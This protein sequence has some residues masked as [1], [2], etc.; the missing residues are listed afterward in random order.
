M[1][2]TA[3]LALLPA[4]NYLRAGVVFIAFFIVAEIVH[5]I[6]ERIVLN[7]AKK[8][9][10]SF[11]DRLV[12]ETRRPVYLILI[13]FGARIALSVSGLASEIILIVGKG[14]YTIIVLIAVVL[15]IRIFEVLIKGWGLDWARETKSRVDK[16]IVNMFSRIAKAFVMIIGLMFL[17][18]IWG[19]NIGPLLASLG[20]A[21]VA[22]AFAMQNT[23]GNIFGGMSLIIDRSVRVG[24]VIEINPETIG[25]VLDVGIR[26]TRIRTYDNEVVIIPNGKL[27]DMHIKNYVQPDY[28]A[29]LVLPFAVAY[30]SSISKVKKVIL[31]EIKKN[32]LAAKDPTPKIRFLEMGDSS[33][34][35]K[36]YVWVDHYGNRYDLKDELNTQIYKA[37]TK[38]KIV[39]PFPQMDVHLKK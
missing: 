21:G 7:A 14:L 27:A 38:A 2:P 20:I 8:T 32:K 17:F 1:N 23:L 26:S 39:I 31:S 9:K 11:D 5:Y 24:D 18:D 37:L 36:A 6:T 13:L 28:S 10:T 16:N 3:F 25:T 19:V 34:K 12:K 4:N 15:A 33:L 29:R 35:F 22:V 30:G